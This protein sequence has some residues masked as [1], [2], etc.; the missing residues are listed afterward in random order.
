MVP[1]LIIHGGAGSAIKD[2]SRKGTVRE[3]LMRIVDAGYTFLSAGSTARQAVV[4]TAEMLEDDP[5]FNAGLGSAIQ[6]D[7]QIRMSA[8]LMDGEEQSFSGVIN[9]QKIQHPIG[10]ANHLQTMRDRVLAWPGTEELARELELPVFN[11]MVQRRLEEWRVEYSDEFKKKAANV[12]AEGDDRGTGTIGVV[13]LDEAG[14]I[15]AGTSTGGRGFEYVGRVSDS[16]TVAGNYATRHA[17]ISATGIGEDIVDAALCARVVTRVTDGMTLREALQ[18][19]M[20]ECEE[21]EHVLG[22]I[23]IDADGNIVWGKTSDILLAAWHDGERC[24]HTVDIPHEPL[25]DSA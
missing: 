7:G 11:P 19:S 25:V 10:V 14:R 15:A 4:H 21:R 20:D 17:G 12:V 18:R 1:K 5:N 9:I 6:S 22:A 2:E 16:A 8:S 24:E 13:A 3:S 23:A